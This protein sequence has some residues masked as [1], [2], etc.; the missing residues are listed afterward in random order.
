MLVNIIR[1]PDA[2]ERV[3]FAL[4]LRIDEWWDEFH[5]LEGLLRILI[6]VIVSIN[7]R[8]IIITITIAGTCLRAISSITGACPPDLCMVRQ[9]L[10]KEV[11]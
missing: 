9:F 5:I 6:S 7:T 1:K 11:Q 10:L 3:I 2:C 8:S 4:T